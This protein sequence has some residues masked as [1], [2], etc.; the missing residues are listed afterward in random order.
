MR[1]AG[2][3]VR[4][5]KLAREVLE[6]ELTAFDR[7][8]DVHISKVRR[9]SA[10]LGR[11]APIETVRG[12]GFTARCRGRHLEET[13]GWGLGVANWRTGGAGFG[14]L[15]CTAFRLKVTPTPNPKSPQF[16]LQIWGR[17]G[18]GPAS[19]RSRDRLRLTTR[20]T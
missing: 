13:G 18:G 17:A 6:R 19:F 5:E 20:I 1:H 7:S 2:Q 10:L 8:L 16:D 12:V 4:R 11:N 15:L 3:V 9:T 14:F